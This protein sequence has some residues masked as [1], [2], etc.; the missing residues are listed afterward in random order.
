[1]RNLMIFAIAISF[2]SLAYAVPQVIFTSINMTI[3]GN[4]STIVYKIAG[5]GINAKDSSF[6]ATN[7]NLSNCS[8][9]ATYYKENIPITFS[10]DFVENQTDIAVLISALKINNNISKM[11]Q[12]CVFNLSTCMAGFGYEE[13]YTACLN[14]LQIFQ[15]SNTE[16]QNQITSNNTRINEL[17]TQRTLIGAAAIIGIIAAFYFYRKNKPKIVRSSINELPS[18]ARM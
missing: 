16:K 15:S 7:L 8:M 1:M 2:I 3:E 4:C 9:N 6:F 11:W 12:E 18:S 17:T 10:R 5:E 14:D 13:N